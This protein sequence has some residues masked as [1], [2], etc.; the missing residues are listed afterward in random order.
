MQALR[1]LRIRVIF[2]IVGA[3]A[4][5][6]CGSFYRQGSVYKETGSLLDLF[7]EPTVDLSIESRTHGYYFGEGVVHRPLRLYDADGH[8]V[9]DVPIV[10]LESALTLPAI[11]V[12]LPYGIQTVRGATTLPFHTPSSFSR[13]K[14]M[15]INALSVGSLLFGFT[16]TIP[17]IISTSGVVA[18]FDV[19]AHDI[20]VTAATGVSRAIG[21]S[22]HYEGEK[23]GSE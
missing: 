6:G 5:N 9:Y 1:D 15:A 20:P 18:V 23:K 3:V 22:S 21:L 17:V 11:L 16:V 13:G 4:A 7:K 2:A 19:A 14:R 8:G 12:S 10:A